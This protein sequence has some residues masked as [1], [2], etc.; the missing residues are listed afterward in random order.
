MLL[1]NGT[2]ISTRV[3]GASVQENLMPVPVSKDRC[4]KILKNRET[5]AVITAQIV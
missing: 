1:A 2:H 4:H 5:L 3:A